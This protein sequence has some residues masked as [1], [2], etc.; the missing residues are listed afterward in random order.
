MYENTSLH[1]TSHW[2]GM[3]RLE[4]LIRSSF[5]TMSAHKI[6][7]FFLPKLKV[8]SSNLK[9]INTTNGMWNS[10][11]LLFCFFFSFCYRTIHNVVYHFFSE[12]YTFLIKTITNRTWSTTLQN[13]HLRP[14]SLLIETSKHVDCNKMCKLLS[15]K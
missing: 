15:I 8:S 7:I 6:N 4:F 13:I 2:L 9:K 12:L 11:G 14:N 5:S 3:L 10:N 1:L